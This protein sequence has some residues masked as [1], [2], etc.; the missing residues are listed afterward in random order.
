MSGMTGT[1]LKK[2]I[3]AN[4]SRRSRETASA[5]RWIAIDE[6]FEAKIAAGG[7]MRVEVAPQR[8]LDRD[9]LEHGLDDEVRVGGGGEVGGRFDA[10]ER[11]VAVVLAEPAL[12]DRTVQVAGDPVAAG[13]GAREVRLVQR[14]LAADRGVDLGDAVAHQPG[15]GHEHSLDRHGRLSVAR[16]ALARAV[17]PRRRRTLV[18]GCPAVVGLMAVRAVVSV[19]AAVAACPRHLTRH[20]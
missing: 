5:S 7:A 18:A 6:V 9:V 8:R 20:G 2:C 11:R 16:G 17:A 19:V 15:P 3:P 13:L 4:R 12:G 10:G 1:G 14:H